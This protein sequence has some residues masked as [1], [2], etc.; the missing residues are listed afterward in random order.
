MRKCA[1]H[2]RG[3]GVLVGELVHTLELENLHSLGVLVGEPVHQPQAAAARS[4]VDACSI[5]DAVVRMP[6]LG[7]VHDVGRGVGSWTSS[8]MCIGPECDRAW[9]SPVHLPPP[10][11]VLP[12]GRGVS[13]SAT[14]RGVPRQRSM[15]GANRTRRTAHTTNGAE[16]RRESRITGVAPR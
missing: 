16:R 5:A 4:G 15:D 14:G 3:R 6:V 11:E 7:T 10:F 2:S 13:P 9:G 12:F 8:P 1:R